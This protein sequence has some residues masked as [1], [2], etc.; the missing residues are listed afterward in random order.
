MCTQCITLNRY[1]TV[2][3]GQKQGVGTTAS[4]NYHVQDKQVLWEAISPQDTITFINIL[5]T[6]AIHITHT[7]RQYLT[8]C[9]Y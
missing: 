3:M 2:I 1:K 5:R 6:T 8:T 7:L 4:R 9:F